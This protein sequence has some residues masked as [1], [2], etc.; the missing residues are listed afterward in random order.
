MR[1]L[2]PWPNFGTIFAFSLEYSKSLEVAEAYY[3]N[4]E[5]ACINGKCVMGCTGA[6]P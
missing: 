5:N 3:G 2:S 1:L 4:L 6:M